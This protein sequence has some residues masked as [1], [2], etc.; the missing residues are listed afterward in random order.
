[1]DEGLGIYREMT[2]ETEKTQISIKE[3]PVSL[4]ARRILNQIFLC[5]VIR[6]VDVR[7]SCNRP[8]KR[9]GKIRK[10]RLFLQIHTFQNNRS[11]ETKLKK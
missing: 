11:G 2:D 10:P 8:D 6:A 5:A 4:S 9:R 1:V 7:E 3:T